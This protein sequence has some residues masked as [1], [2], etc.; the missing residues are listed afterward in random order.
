M[1][2][3]RFTIPDFVSLSSALTGVSAAQLRPDVDPI[4]IADQYF[5]TLTGNVSAAI[6][7][8]LAAKFR[9][10]ADPVEA[11]GQILDDPVFGLI[12]RSIIKL[13]LLG[14]WYNPVNPS[15]AIK[16]V[17]AQA[18]KESL[19]W[20]VMQSHPMGYSMFQFGY[21]SETPPPL[22]QFIQP[23]TASAGCNGGAGHG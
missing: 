7:A 17:S 21:W 2:N 22:D 13:W 23:S 14:Q 11:A 3:P 10:I 16:V 19:V 20:K 18:Y 9:A 8:D 1:D 5:D 6:L 4:G 12:A 15:Q